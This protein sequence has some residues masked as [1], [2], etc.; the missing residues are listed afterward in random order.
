MVASPAAV[1]GRRGVRAPRR[2]SP[3]RHGGPHAVT[4]AGQRPGETAVTRRVR[5]LCRGRTG[6]MTEQGSAISARWTHLADRLPA[7]LEELSGTDRGSV[8]LRSHLAWSGL[9]RCAFEGEQLL[10]CRKRRRLVAP[11]AGLVKAPPATTVT[12]CGAPSRSATTSCST[13]QTCSSASTPHA[14]TGAGAEQLKAEISESLKRPWLCRSTGLRTW[15]RPPDVAPLTKVRRQRRGYPRLR[16]PPAVPCPSRSRARAGQ[17]RLSLGRRGCPRYLI[18]V[19]AMPWTICRWKTRKTATSG[20]KPRTEEAMTSAY[21][22]LLLLT[23]EARPT[24]MV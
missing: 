3:S 22:M 7:S 8:E 24:G 9:T 21:W 16:R 11:H 18:P 17:D 23:R 2:V 15:L 1:A 19:V 10:L 14:R 5:P 6:G 20:R 12:S 4:R 13:P